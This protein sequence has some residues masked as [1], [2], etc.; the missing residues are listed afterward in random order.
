MLV[1]AEL[2]TARELAEQF[3]TLAQ[4]DTKIPERSLE[5]SRHLGYDVVLP[6]GVAR[7]PEHLEQAI[8]L[9]DP[10]QH[11][12]IWPVQYG[13]DP[14]MSSLILC[15]VYPVVS[16]LSG[17]GPQKSPGGA[18]RLAQELAHPFT[19]VC[20]WHGALAA[21]VPP[22]DALVRKS[23]QKRPW[24]SRREQGFP[25]WLAIWTGHAGLGAR[26]SRDKERRESRRCARA[27]GWRSQGYGAGGRPYWLALLAEAYGKVGQVEEGLSCTGRGAAV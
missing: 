2:Q 18:V 10:Q 12:V 26:A 25:Y 3:L 1:R 16:G 7:R 13:H 23:R 27:A 9:Y 21:S 6:G 14:G 15:G 8:A 5:A 20:L 22:G 17:P 24:R 4:S 11:G 19:C